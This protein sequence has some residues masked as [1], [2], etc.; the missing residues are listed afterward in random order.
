MLIDLLKNDPIINQFF[1]DECKENDISIEIDNTI[2]KDDLL[3][4]KLD[5]Y[6]HRESHPQPPSP[7][8]LVIQ[9]CSENKFNG[10]IIELKNIDGPGG[11][12]VNGIVQKFTTCLDDFMSNRF[13]HYFYKNEINYNSIRLIF[14]ADPYDYKKVP[15]KQN[16]AK[17]HRIDALLSVRIPKYFGHHLY[18]DH[19]LPNPKI[20]NCKQPLAS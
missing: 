6:Y 17:P 3:I 12:T 7:D 8:C 4:I 13:A 18:I 20:N 15:E 9:R 14:I 1:C 5:E 10:Y 16:K 2:S 19:K 11:F